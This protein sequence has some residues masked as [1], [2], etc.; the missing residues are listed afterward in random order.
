[1][2][3]WRYKHVADTP[4]G[5]VAFDTLAEGWALTDS[6]VLCDKLELQGVIAPC[7]FLYSLAF[8]PPLLHQPWLTERDSENVFFCSIHGFGEVKEDL[9][10]AGEHRRTLG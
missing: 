3:P 6:S 5:E 2:K 4:L 7:L 9:G 1:M 10:E 8:P